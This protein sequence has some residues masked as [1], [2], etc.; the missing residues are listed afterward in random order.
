LTRLAEAVEVN[1][2]SDSPQA[3][4]EALGHAVDVLD[5][6][7]EDA[8]P[9]AH[10]SVDVISPVLLARQC[11]GVRLEVAYGLEAGVPDRLSMTAEKR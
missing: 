11:D 1:A 7:L 8:L 4:A 6:A 9:K 3:R 2:V 5:D 10:C